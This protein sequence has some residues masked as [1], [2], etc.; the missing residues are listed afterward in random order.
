M[1]HKSLDHEQVGNR[2]Q[3]WVL[4]NK[5]ALAFHFLLREKDKIEHCQTNVLTPNG[6]RQISSFSSCCGSV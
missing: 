1:D 5:A 2:K 6:T 4:R 3:S